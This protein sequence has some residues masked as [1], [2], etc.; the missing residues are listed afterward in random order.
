MR[1]YSDGR[2]KLIKDYKNKGRDEFYDLVKDPAEKINLIATSDPI[3]QQ[4][5]NTFDD[6]IFSKML[7]TSDPE[8]EQ[9][10]GKSND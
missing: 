6:I 4:R 5:I 10:Y 7:A 1:M 8:L 2:Y 3:Y 9:F